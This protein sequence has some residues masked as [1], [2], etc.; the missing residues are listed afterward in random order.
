VTTL[1]YTPGPASAGK[2]ADL[3]RAGADGIR[4]T[5]S[6]AT[7]EYQAEQAALHHD[8]ARKTGRPCLVLADLAGEKFRLGQFSL[9]PSLQVVAGERLTIHFGTSSD[10]ERDR[11][12]AVT[13]EQFFAQLA[14]GDLI[15]V[16]DGSATFSV[17]AVDSPGSRATLQATQGGVVNQGRGLTIQGTGFSPRCLTGKDLADLESIA[18]TVEFDAVALSFVADP[19]DVE[20]AR[21][22]LAD[23]P[24]PMPIIAKIETQAGL[25]NVDAICNVADAVL[26]A[27]GDLALTIPWIELPAAVHRIAKAAS[28][29][30]RPWILATQIVEGLERFVFPTRAEICDLAS[31]LSAGCAGVLLSYETAFGARPVEAVR[32]TRQIIN[33]WA[34]QPDSEP[35]W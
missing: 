34:P 3:L 6:H 4:L 17:T 30:G 20:R 35:A 19:S 1:W 12:L 23:R 11:E 32:A 26:A 16:G 28:S 9:Q 2:E 21:A 15:T 14:A 33:R 27:R 7:R 29:A 18:R 22:M 24:H 25:D 31:W 8:V 10:P 13:S 5:F